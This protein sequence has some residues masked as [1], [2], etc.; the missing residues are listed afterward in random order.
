M[1][2]WNDRIYIYCVWKLL[3]R[4][5]LFVTPWNSPWNSSGQNTGVG[6]R[7][8]LQ[9]IFPTQGLNPDLPHCRRIL[10]QLSHQ[11][12]S[13]PL[14]WIAHSFSGGFSWPENQTGVSYIA[15]GFFTNWATREA[16]TSRV[17]TKNKTIKKKHTL[18]GFNN[19]LHEA[20]E[21]VNMETIQWNTCKPKSRKNGETVKTA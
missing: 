11:G 13:R 14:E 12:S 7:S 9:G 4:V 3:S 1:T 17:K 21:S 15:G 20:E 18:E 16:T 2:C 19:R 5:W 8:L 6:C 10:Y